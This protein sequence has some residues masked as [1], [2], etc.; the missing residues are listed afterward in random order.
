MEKVVEAQQ[1]VRGWWKPWCPSRP[2]CPAAGRLEA[3]T[4]RGASC[5][6]DWTGMEGCLLAGNHDHGPSSRW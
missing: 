4:C 6:G 2:C 1:A 5:P 3:E